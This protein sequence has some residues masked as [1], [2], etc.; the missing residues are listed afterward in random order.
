MERQ[1][2]AGSDAPAWWASTKLPNIFGGCEMKYIS[3]FQVREYIRKGFEYGL[4]MRQIIDSIR[5]INE[6]E[7]VIIQG[8][9]GW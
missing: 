9:Y 5:I 8:V 4:T 6:R 3:R 1:V 2:I 7:R